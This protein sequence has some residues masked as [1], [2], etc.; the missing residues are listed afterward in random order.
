MGNESHNPRDAA[1]VQEIRDQVAWLEERGWKRGDEGLWRHP[2]KAADIGLTHSGAFTV[3][4]RSAGA[5][6]TLDA[7]P[8]DATPGRE[9]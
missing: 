1:D 6:R 4:A 7:G 5:S 3:E 2:A 8:L 9:A